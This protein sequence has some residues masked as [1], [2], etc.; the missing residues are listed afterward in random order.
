MALTAQTIEDRADIDPAYQDAE[1]EPDSQ[2]P[3]K[4]PASP[5]TKPMGIRQADGTVVPY[6]SPKAMAVPVSV[7]FHLRWRSSAQVFR[8]GDRR[9]ECC[10]TTYDHPS[11]IQLMLAGGVMQKRK[12]FRTMIG[13][14]T[15]CK[16]RRTPPILS[17]DLWRKASSSAPFGDCL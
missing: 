1:G 10:R 17:Q 7:D 16:R 11:S 4:L 9:M 6:A 15:L 13:T 14:W 8:A 12:T 2:V 5:V 3:N